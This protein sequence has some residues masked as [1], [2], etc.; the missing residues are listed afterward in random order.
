MLLRNI[1]PQEGLCNGSRMVVTDLMPYSIGVKMLGGEFDGQERLI[2]RI[3]FVVENTP[4]GIAVIRKQLP[5]R[6]C[7][8]MT[9]NK[10]QGQSFHTVGLDLRTP[11]FAHGQLYVALSRT[12]SVTGLAAL[13]PE[14]SE[15][16]TKNVVYPE[17][18]L[19]IDPP[20][21]PV[22]GDAAAGD[23]GHAPGAGAV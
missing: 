20:P 19:N 16:R 4:L 23:E 8:A 2:P 6:M 13:L 10:S 9:I 12:S 18:L 11:V 3:D 15:G 17:V 21:A 1:C 5:V 14:N 7:F 22:L